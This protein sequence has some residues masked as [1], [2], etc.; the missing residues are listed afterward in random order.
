MS[1]MFKAI[2]LLLP[3]VSAVMLGSAAVAPTACVSST[4]FVLVFVTRGLK[5]WKILVDKTSRDPVDVIWYLLQAN[6]RTSVGIPFNSSS[7]FR[8]SE[9][10][11]SPGCSAL[12][13]VFLL[14]LPPSTM[15]IQHNKVKNN[16]ISIIVLM[17]NLIIE[18]IN[19]TLIHRNDFPLTT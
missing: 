4:E 19:F 1:G 15:A 3:M 9:L 10:S 5:N 11:T 14:S 17:I 18:D 6:R 13:L 2:L 8:C 12:A 7:D 16:I